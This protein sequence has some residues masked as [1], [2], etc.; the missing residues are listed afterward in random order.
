MQS[1]PT[2]PPP[3]SKRARTHS[4]SAVLQSLGS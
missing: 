4:R 2:L 1:E 3:A